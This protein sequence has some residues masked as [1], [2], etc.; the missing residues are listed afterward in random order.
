[1]PAQRPTSTAVRSAAAPACGPATRTNSV[2]AQVA[3]ASGAAASHYRRWDSNPHG[4]RPPEDFKSPGGS[5]QGS[6]HLR[7]VKIRPFADSADAAR[8]PADPE[9]ALVADAWPALPAAVRAGI[10][11]L[12]RASQPATAADTQPATDTP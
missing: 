2:R 5:F 8:Q 11:A 10:V 9:L 4:G 12:V 3:A 7:L 1:M 6:K